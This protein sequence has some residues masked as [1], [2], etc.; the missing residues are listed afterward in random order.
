MVAVGACAQ[1]F[2]GVWVV[3]VLVGV[4]VWVGGGAITAAAVHRSTARESAGDDDEVVMIEGV[5]EGICGEGA[6]RLNRG[7][8]GW[9]SGKVQLSLMRFHMVGW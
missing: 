9:G 3:S 7:A 4:F 6:G 1:V 2:V 5:D 8:G